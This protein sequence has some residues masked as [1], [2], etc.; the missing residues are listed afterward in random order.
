MDLYDKYE[1]QRDRFEVLAFHDG[2]VKTFEELDEKMEKTIAVRWKGRSLPFPILLDASGTTVKQ[3]GISA[4]PTHVLID[5]DG[6]V[7]KGDEKL[8]E[9]KL[10]A[11]LKQELVQELE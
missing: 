9:K 10:L 2:T 11:E 4:F 7:V 8:L 5:P 3:L 6:N 1:A